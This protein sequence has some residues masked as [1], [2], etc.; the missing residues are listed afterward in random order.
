MRVVHKAESV[1][2]GLVKVGYYRET[3]NDSGWFYEINREDTITERV[4][5]LMI[6]EYVKKIS[7]SKNYGV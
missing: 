5:Q 3:P 4:S 1:T 2:S 7:I 6:D